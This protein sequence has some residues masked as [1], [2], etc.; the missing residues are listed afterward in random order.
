ML[1]T[2]YESILLTLLPR[3]PPLA[4]FYVSSAS[5]FV[6]LWR[7]WIVCHKDFYM[8]TDSET[9]TFWI[10]AKNCSILFYLSLLVGFL[11]TI[12]DASMFL[13]SGK[14]IKHT[15]TF[16][17]LYLPLPSQTSNL[18][19]QSNQILCSNYVDWRKMQATAHW[20]VKSTWVGV[21]SLM[22]LLCVRK[23]V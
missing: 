1:L 7:L 21:T 2:N 20:V 19:S 14:N 8:I 17:F 4:S 11:W 12:W 23:Y 6:P 9:K 22:E 5:I 10:Y 3:T 15:H 16:L 18:Q 13:N